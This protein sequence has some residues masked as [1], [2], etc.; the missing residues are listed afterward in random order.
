MK[1]TGKNRVALRLW[2]AGMFGV[3]ALSIFVLPQSLAG[4]ELPVA[5]EIAILISTI[6]NAVFL[7]VAAWVGSHLAQKV[8]LRAP[9]AQALSTKG[10]LKDALIPQIGPGIVGGAIGAGLLIIAPVFL[11]PQL[12]DL[13]SSIAFPLVVK[14]FYG[15]IT[16]E[17]LLRW[18]ILT[19][20]VWGAWMLF[21]KKQGSPKVGVVWLAI[22]LSSLLFA[23][24][25]LPA[26]AAFAKTALTNDAIAYVLIVNS[27]FGL[28]AG[29]L[30][31]RFGLESAIVAHII[32]HVLSHYVGLL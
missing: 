4:R 25:H 12:A 19:F 6:Q 8:G 9:S 16:E 26:A 15:G 24:G 22:I 5:L 20:L 14:I 11:P 27:L 3:L 29:F 17:V 31:W 7:A 23:A 32:A 21:Q 10:M 1:L 30:Y 18:G 2:V 13:G 28:V